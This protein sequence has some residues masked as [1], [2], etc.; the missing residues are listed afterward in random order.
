MFSEKI[1]V[2]I[3]SFSSFLNIYPIK[4][5]VKHFRPSFISESMEEKF[6]TF[7]NFF[8]LARLG[9]SGP[10]LDMII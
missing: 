9:K 5:K 6:S 1:F 4:L 7:Y 3:K 10:L 2:F 8:K